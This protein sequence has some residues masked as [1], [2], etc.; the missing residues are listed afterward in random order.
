MAVGPSG[1]IVIEIDPDQKQELYVALKEDN[2]NLKQWFL[3]R[4]EEYLRDRGQ[5]SLRLWSAD[6]DE[7][8]RKYG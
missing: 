6:G 1:R 5:L 4:V 2:L 3:E 8:K 7:D